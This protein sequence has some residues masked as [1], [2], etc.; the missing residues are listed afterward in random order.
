MV[1]GTWML[2]AYV[3]WTLLWQPAWQT[4]REAPQHRAQ[5]TQTLQTLHGLAA[6]A[7]QWR[8]QPTMTRASRDAALQQLAQAA[9]VTLQALPDGWQVQ[10]TQWPPATLAQ[11][12][13][14]VRNQAHADVVQ[15]DLRRDGA[16]WSGT[17]RIRTELQP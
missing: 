15:S 11:W 5:A 10:I 12:L 14:D 1:L 9:S 6:Q 16:A 4:L 13:V 3:L 17:L 8:A 7:E 2:A